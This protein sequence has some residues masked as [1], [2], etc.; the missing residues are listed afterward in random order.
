MRLRRGVPLSLV[1]LALICLI[2]AV[3]RA[4][5]AAC[6]TSRVGE[7][8]S[9][10]LAAH[11]FDG[12]LP[13]GWTIEEVAVARDHID[14]GTLDEQ[15]RP[16]SVALR[17]PRDAA[18]PGDGRG[19]SFV[20]V[21]DGGAV[22]LDA[23]G[24]RGLLEL[25]A[26]VDAAVPEDEALRVCIGGHDGGLSWAARGAPLPRWVAL[27]VGFLEVMVVLGAL[28]FALLPS[29][30]EGRASVKARDRIA[31]WVDLAVFVFAWLALRAEGGGA[32]ILWLDTINDHRD[33]T[34]CLVRDACTGLGEAASVEGVHHAVGWIDFL[35]LASFAGL[36]LGTL[37]LVLQASNALGV[38]LAGSVARQAWGRTA[39]IFA[40]GACF[41]G[42]ADTVE[43]HAL[44]NG[45]PLPFLGAVLL[46]A[47]V[48]VA[49]RP[50]AAGI[51]SIAALGAVLASVHSACVV[52]LASV[53][54][55]ALLAP[56][57]PF[58]LAALGV[59]VFLATALV[60]GPAAW[61][62][63]VRHVL[64]AMTGA[65]GTHHTEAGVPAGALMTYGTLAALSLAARL[66]S[67]PRQRPPVNAAL[68]IALPILAGSLAAAATSTVATN[69]KYLAFVT[70][71]LAVLAAML[72]GAVSAWI[73][74]ALAGSKEPP[75]G[76]LR[77]LPSLMFSVL[78]LVG[79]RS[80]VV[81]VLRGHA[82]SH[83]LTF[84]DAD[85]IQRL[86]AARGWSF[87]QV[88]RSLRSPDAAVILASFELGP[89][90]SLGAAAD[91][92]Q[93]VYV[94][95]NDAALLPK[96]LPPS[97]VLANQESGS[98]LVLAF[99]RSFLSWDHFRVCDPRA[100]AGPEPCADSGLS[101]RGQEMPTCLY[102]VP[103]MPPF[104]R[105]GE[106]A[107]E[108]RLPVQSTAGQAHAIEMP[109]RPLLCA[110][111]IASVPGGPA[112]I[113]ADHRRAT[114]ASPA[115]SMPPQ[116]VRLEWTIGSPECDMN[117]YS[118][119]PPFF[120][121]GDPETVAQLDRLEW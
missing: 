86:L 84:D 78:A 49:R 73:V 11:D 87:A 114:W 98:A 95:K 54:W 104:H 85:A 43:L 41:A 48:A 75:A 81:P 39:G 24:R 10:K 55:I 111:S 9:A 58:R 22:P 13:A 70:P 52:T 30:R 77:L 28:V 108:L 36:R 82:R 93:V 117:S 74:G 16:R 79:L 12:A 71:S 99:T 61:V 57:R 56:R 47:C 113:S 15:R 76:L 35:D 69:A 105:A 3:A 1:V 83:P 68:A 97:W 45:T 116:E 121:E 64:S 50:T 40:A 91:D 112:A 34:L 65:K 25:A 8:L 42:A 92:S 31:L 109:A 62:T 17:L 89:Q 107:M 119:M 21:I 90:L 72:V 23:A 88:Y 53:V 29:L 18:G 32:P 27:S 96:P 106:Q 7:I 44:Y 66:T 80:F 20:F 14:L 59:V 103:G 51:A 118:G 37:H 67:P 60:I 120:L 102:C 38:V 94:A 2:S 5:P 4:D 6:L 46:V 101:I 26:R 110:G 19:R 100:A 33:V 63:S 115:G